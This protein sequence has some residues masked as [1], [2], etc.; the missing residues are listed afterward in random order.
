MIASILMIILALFLIIKPLESVASLII[1]FGI[2]TVI[3]GIVHIIS[4]FKTDKEM[5]I[6]SFELIEGI[7]CIL[8]GILIIAFSRYLSAVFPIMLGIW[9][10][11]K[12]LLRLQLAI[13]LKNVPE[14]GWVGILILSILIIIL[15][16]IMIINPFSSMIAITTLAGIFLLLTEIAN[17]IE[18]IYTLNK[19]KNIK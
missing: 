12:N 4:Y 14:S 9:I 17:L 13:N 5:R 19:V 3:D 18:S 6:I 11:V 2:I 8:S 15:G 16:I 7:L 10:I 1:L